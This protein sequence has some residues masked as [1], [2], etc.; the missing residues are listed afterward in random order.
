ML[1][2]R[3]R[4]E[5][6]AEGEGGKG[7]REEGKG[8]ERL[9]RGGGRQGKRGRG[10]VARRG[11]TTKGGGKRGREGKCGL[12][13]EAKE[14]GLGAREGAYHKSEPRVNVKKEDRGSSCSEGARGCERRE[15]KR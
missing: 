10:A 11:G 1:S 2:K 7:R 3:K 8:E 5:R 9:R 4:D 15:R 14:K 13:G 12:G 6:Q